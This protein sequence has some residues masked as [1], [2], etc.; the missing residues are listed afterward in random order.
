GSLSINLKGE[1]SREYI[2]VVYDV[3]GRSRWQQHIK[4]ARGGETTITAPTSGF[5]SGV[6]LVCCTDLLS[7]KSAFQKAILLR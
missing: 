3:T 5:A 6:Y 4:I 7:K 2:L 1:K